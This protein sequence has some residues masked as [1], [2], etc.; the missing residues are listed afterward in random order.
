MTEN[1]KGN[2]VIVLP[3]LE[4]TPLNQMPYID[5]IEKNLDRDK[6]FKKEGDLPTI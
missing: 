4:I 2:E 1:L 3:S 6:K 5:I